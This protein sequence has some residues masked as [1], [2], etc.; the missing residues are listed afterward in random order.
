MQCCLFRSTSCF[1]VRLLP[2]QNDKRWTSLHCDHCNVWR[3]DSR[4]PSDIHVISFLIRKVSQRRCDGAWLIWL[5]ISLV[6]HMR[7]CGN[8]YNDLH[9]LLLISF[10][11]SFFL[12]HTRVF[13]YQQTVSCPLCLPPMQVKAWIQKSFHLCRSDCLQIKQQKG[14]KVHVMRQQRL[15]ALSVLVFTAIADQPDLQLIWYGLHSFF[16][17][18]LFFLHF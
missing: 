17:S 4:R 7:G 18:L 9:F 8:V 6:N 3:W 12:F 10:F 5:F 13:T 2:V 11:L 1:I 14:D 15:A 16:T